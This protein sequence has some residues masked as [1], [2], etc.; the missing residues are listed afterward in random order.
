M[1]EIPQTTETPDVPTTHSFTT[2]KITLEKVEPGTF[3]LPHHKLKQHIETRPYSI[4]KGT[5]PSGHTR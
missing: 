2:E 1:E 4:I 5:C 3:K